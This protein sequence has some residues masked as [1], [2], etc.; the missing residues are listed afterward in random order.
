[1]STLQGARLFH[2]GQLDGHRIRI[3]V[4]LGRGPDEPPDEELRAFYGRLLR[5][6]S[7]SDLRGGAWSLCDCSGWPDNDSARQLVAWCWSAPGSRHLVVVNL[8]AAAAQ[9]RVH[10]PWDDL[11]GRNWQLQDRLSGAR[12][13]RDGGELAAEGLYVALDGWQSHFLGISY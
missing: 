2:D 6:V 4:F 5:A 1:M 9:A 12:F 7:D 13:E 3:P 8:S 11:T 10:V